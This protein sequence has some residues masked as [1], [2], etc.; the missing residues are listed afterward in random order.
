MLP[1][2]FLCTSTDIRQFVLETI[3]SPT[4]FTNSVNV[5]IVT[6]HSTVNNLN[7]KVRPLS[8]RTNVT[9]SC[10]ATSKQSNLHKSHQKIPKSCCQST[11][12]VLLET[13]HNCIV[14][15]LRNVRLFQDFQQHKT[16]LAFPQQFL[17]L[18]FNMQAAASHTQE[19]QF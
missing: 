13:Q 19:R 11:S 16:K 18:Q 7:F 1:V 8:K 10:N 9:L 17:A 3:D 6:S 2:V 12:E 4:Y 15:L 14:N 5:H